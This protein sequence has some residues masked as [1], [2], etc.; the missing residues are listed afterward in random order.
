M[1]NIYGPTENTTATTT[2]DITLADV[3]GVVPIGRPVSGA[4]LHVVRP[5]GTEAEPGEAGELYIGGTGLANGYHLA[6]AM[7]AAAFVPDPFGQ[8]SGGRLYRTGDFVRQ[9]PDGA[10]G[11]VGRNDDQVKVRGFRVELGEI[12]LAIRRQEHVADVAVLSRSTP[13]SAELTAFVTGTAP[14][15]GAELTRRLRQELPDQMVPAIVVLDRMPMTSNGKIDR[16]ALATAIPGPEPDSAASA[17]S[18]K[19]GA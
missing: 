1:V 7:T 17:G 10:F 9:L 5:D 8:A 4:V 11:F 12:D 3:A 15:D 19:Q 13:D 2:H 18:P 14:L 6:P 16:R